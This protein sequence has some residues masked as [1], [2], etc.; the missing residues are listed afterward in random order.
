M[1]SSQ[2]ITAMNDIYEKN[3]TVELQSVYWAKGKESNHYDF[4]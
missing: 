3:H 4:I 2:F 1:K